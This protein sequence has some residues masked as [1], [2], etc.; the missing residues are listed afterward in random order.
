MF[1]PRNSSVWAN[2]S[3][4]HRHTVQEGRLKIR[5]LGEKTMTDVRLKPSV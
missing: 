1:G 2:D 4:R 5:V 3:N